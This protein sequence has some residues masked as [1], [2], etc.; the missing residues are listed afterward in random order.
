M[1]GLFRAVVVAELA[2]TLAQSRQFVEAEE[3]FRAA[4][5]VL[6]DVPAT[7]H[8]LLARQLSSDA[9]AAARRLDLA[10]QAKKR[11]LEAEGTRIQ[12]QLALVESV[13]ATERCCCSHAVSTAACLLCPTPALKI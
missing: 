6:L 2:V 12:I 1:D 8:Q 11:E 9:A 13:R 3:M 7:A 10:L 4:C 5:K